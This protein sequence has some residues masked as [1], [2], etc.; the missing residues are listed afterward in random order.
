M[1]RIGKPSKPHHRCGGPP[2]RQAGEEG[3]GVV[4]AALERVLSEG[5]SDA[6]ANPSPQLAGEMSPQRQRGK[7]GR[8]TKQLKRKLAAMKPHHRCGGPPPRQAGEEGAGVMCTEL[9]WRVLS[10][11]ALDATATPSPQLAGEMSPQRQRGN[12]VYFSCSVSASSLPISRVSFFRY[13]N[14]CSSHT[15]RILVQTVS[16]L[17]RIWRLVNRRTRIP[18]RWMN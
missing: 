3:A 13:R 7:P 18:S 17:S 12:P 11:G 4:C 6:A 15:S 14:G 1:L 2:P 10:K 8:E 16:K 9:D 5:I